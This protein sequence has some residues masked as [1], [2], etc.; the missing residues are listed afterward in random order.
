MTAVK[1]VQEIV[2]AMRDAIPNLQFRLDC[3]KVRDLNTEVVEL[4]LR[5]IPLQATELDV[6]RAVHAWA[7]DFFGVDTDDSD[8]EEATEEGEQ[9]TASLILGADDLRITEC[10]D[11]TFVNAMDIREVCSVLLSMKMQ[12]LSPTFWCQRPT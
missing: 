4:V 10:I 5:H 1:E 2:V 11:L 9:S 3:F 8:S 6:C 7:Q 12:S